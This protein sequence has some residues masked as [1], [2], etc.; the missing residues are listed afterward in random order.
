MRLQVIRW[1]SIALATVVLAAACGG[2][3]SNTNAIGST[4]VNHPNIKGK[5]VRIVIN[6]DLEL[7]KIV[8]AH[9]EGILQGWGANIQTNYGGTSQVVMGA[10]V[11][12][13]A[14][15]LEFSAQGTLSAINNGV[16]LKAFALPQPRQ[17][18]ALIGRPN[19]RTLSDLKGAKIGV[20]D[21]VGLNGIQAKFALQAAGLTT[22]DVHIIQVGGQGARVAALIAGRIDATMVGFM[23]V[24]TLQPQGYNLLYSYTKERPDLFDDLFWASPDWLKN[25]ADVAQAFNQALLEAFRWFDN[26][27]NKQAFVNETAA[28]VKGTDLGVTAQ[29]YDV[30]I[31]NNMYP[32]NGIMTLDALT[33]NQQAYV[34]SGGLPKALPVSQWADVS[35]AQKALAAEGTVK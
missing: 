13:Q 7:S 22:N 25:N 31:Q 12:G 33:S 16:V 15:V 5:T 21:T 24:L 1:L 6:G 9:A 14:D 10:M 28:A 35:F 32:A 2:S 26:S 18:Y 34:D 30:Y 19:I 27:A 23:N 11:S 8:L 17:D 4:T 20:L 29:M 3:S